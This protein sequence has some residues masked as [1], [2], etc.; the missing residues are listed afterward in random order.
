MIWKILS[1]SWQRALETRPRMWLDSHVLKRLAVWLMDPI[2]HLS[3]SQTQRC[4]YPG[5]I[6]SCPMIWPALNCT[7]GQWVVFRIL[8]QQPQ[9]QPA[10]IEWDREDIE[11][12]KND[13]RADP[14]IERLLDSHSHHGLRAWAKGVQPSP[15][16]AWSTEYG[17]KADHSQALNGICPVMFWISLVSTIPFFLSD[18]FL[19]EW[20]CLPWAWPTT[21]FW[22]HTPCLVSQLHSR[23]GIQD[24]SDLR[25]QRFQWYWREIWDSELMC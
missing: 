5:N 11:W 1:L 25:S 23:R 8:Y 18:F 21:A 6:Q 20:E 13:F 3:R 4:C 9:C 12:R 10:W 7:R 22:K 14:W 2:K 16:W 17:A 15:C 19:L 24:E